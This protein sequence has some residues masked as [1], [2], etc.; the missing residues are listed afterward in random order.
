MEA[1]HEPEVPGEVKMKCRACSREA[2]ADL[3]LYHSE[4]K[5]KLQAAYP[6]WVEAYGTLGWKDY[7]DSVKHNLQTGQWVKEIAELLAGD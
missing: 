3:C 4:A 6:R 2:V 5:D 7:L 1:V